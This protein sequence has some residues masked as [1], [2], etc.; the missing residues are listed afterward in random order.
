[1]RSVNRDNPQFEHVTLMSL[2]A[3]RVRRKCL[4]VCVSGLW[5]KPRPWVFVVSTGC[6]QVMVW[7]RYTPCFLDTFLAGDFVVFG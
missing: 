1:M 6:E 3:T 5:K 4:R 2:Y 7:F